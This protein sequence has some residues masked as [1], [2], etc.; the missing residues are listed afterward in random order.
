[1]A[2]SADSHH[3]NRQTQYSVVAYAIYI[4]PDILLFLYDWRRYTQQRSQSVVHTPTMSCVVYIKHTRYVLPGTAGTQ[5]IIHVCIVCMYYVLV[6]YLLCVL[7]TLRRGYS[8]ANSFLM[9]QPP[10][11][12]TSKIYGGG[13]TVSSIP[14]NSVSNMTASRVIDMMMY[15]L[16]FVRSTQLKIIIIKN[17]YHMS[18]HTST[19]YTS[20]YIELSSYLFVVLAE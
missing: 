16:L 5:K 12:T 3:N 14:N 6:Q 20:D 7:Y 18:Y 15:V 11:N 13:G 2:L 17:M 19:I 9:P 1:M 4:L 8:I 10:Q